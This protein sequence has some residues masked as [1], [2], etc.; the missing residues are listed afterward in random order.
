MELSFENIRPYNPEELHDAFTRLIEEPAFLQLV[1]KYIPQVPIKDLCAQLLN[2]R[3]ATAFQKTFIVPLLY[4]IEA[5]HSKGI[6]ASGIQNTN[7]PALLISNHRDIVMDSALMDLVLLRA[8]SDSVEIGI[9]DN[10]LATPW[11]RTLV[12]INKSFIVQRNLPIRE[13]PKAFLELSSYIRHAI[14]TKQTSVWIAQREGRAKDSNDRTQESIL[15]MFALSGTKSFIDNLKDLNICPVTISYEHDPCDYLK[16][17]EF[18]QKRDDKDFT[19]SSQDDLLSMKTGILGDKGHVHFT[20]TAS[21]NKELEQIATSIDKRKDQIEAI[22]QLIDHRIHSNYVIY[23]INKVAYD[24]LLNTT[25]FTTEVTSEERANVK[26]YLDG[27]LSKIELP[28]K[29]YEFLQHKLLEMYANPLINYLA[30]Q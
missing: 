13:M 27:Q 25:R 30:A 1:Q 26:Q 14:T 8:G 24:E 9:G 10:L 2:I 28:N 7:H 3:T 16:A 15:K 6:T 20:F 19:K 4:A 22:A 29:D 17:K 18:Q 12:R 11:I 23:P 21:I 5:K